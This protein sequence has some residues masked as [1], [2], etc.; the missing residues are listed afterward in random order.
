[1]SLSDVKIAN[2]KTALDGAVADPA[3]GI[4]I[5]PLT[6]DP[7]FGTYITEIPPKGKVGAHYHCEGVEVYGIMSGSGIIHTAIPDENNQP[8][9][10]SSKPVTTGDFFNIDSGVIHQLEN[11]ASEPLILI[12]GC[13]ATHLN[14]D[15]ILTCDLTK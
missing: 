12:F 2:F 8:T 3:V 15:R 1:M 10:I 9:D 6:Q 4:K 13:P 14:T 7:S 5:A 11:I